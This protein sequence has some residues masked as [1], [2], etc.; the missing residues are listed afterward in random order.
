MNSEE[1]VPFVSSNIDN[2]SSFSSALLKFSELPK[3]MRDN[4]YILS[5]Y[6]APT[7]SYWKSAQSLFYIHNETGNVYSHLLGAVLFFIV[8]IFTAAKIFPQFETTHWSDF[9]VM[10]IFI[11]GAIACLCCSTLYHLFH[12]HSEKVSVM[13]NRCDYV[14]IVFLIVGSYFPAINYAFYCS[15]VWKIVYLSFILAFGLATAVMSIAKRFGKPEYRWIRTNLFLAMGL[16]GICPFAHAIWANGWTIAVQKLSLKWFGSMG[17]TYVCG[18][19][20]YASRVPERWFPGKF[21]YIGHSHQIFHVC[22]VIA[23]VFH[24]IGV[25]KA[26]RWSHLDSHSCSLH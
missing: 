16:S 11:A 10:Y 8:A 26:Y 24:Y 17:L 6:R 2:T 9:A 21:D 19:L 7:S 23:A 15:Q 20:I 14:G 4:N 18:A 25:V 22:V 13:W 5:G 12:C 1:T 3:W